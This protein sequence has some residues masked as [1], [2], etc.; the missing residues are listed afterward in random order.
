[1]KRKALNLLFILSLIGVTIA[2]NDKNAITKKEKNVKKSPKTETVIMPDGTESVVTKPE[3][4]RSDAVRT[5]R[6]QP[7][8]MEAV[9]VKEIKPNEPK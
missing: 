4:N 7:S 2:Q 5:Q 1:M 9:E 6:R 3:E 8:K